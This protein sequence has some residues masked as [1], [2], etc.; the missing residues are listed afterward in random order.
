M[1]T[2]GGTQCKRYILSYEGVR[3]LKSEL[4]LKFISMFVSLGES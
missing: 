4:V 2:G 3:N 1:A